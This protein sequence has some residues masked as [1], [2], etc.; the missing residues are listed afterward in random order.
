MQA[1]LTVVCSDHLKLYFSSILRLWLHFI[2][3]GTGGGGGGGGGGKH[4]V[5]DT[6][7]GFRHTPD[8]PDSQIQVKVTEKERKG[9]ESD[10]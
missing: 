7:S 10:N 4:E 9:K 6:G 2:G 8:R 3:V 5:Q 1:F